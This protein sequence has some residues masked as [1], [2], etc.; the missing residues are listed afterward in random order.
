M[1]T[2]LTPGSGRLQEGLHY[3]GVTTLFNDPAA[4]SRRSFITQAQGGVAIHAPI[5]LL[6]YKAG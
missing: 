6:Q 3:L 2:D 1:T 5:T 4:L